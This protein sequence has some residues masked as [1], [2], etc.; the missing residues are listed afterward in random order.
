MSF[1]ADQLFDLVADVES[2]P[3]F[4]PWCSGARVISREARGGKTIMLADMTISFKIHQETF[5]SEV[6]LDREARTI[7]TRYVNGPFKRMVSEWR[8][9]PAGERATNVNFFIDFEFRN[10]AL[11]MLI[12]LLFEEAVRR[13]VAAFASRAEAIYGKSV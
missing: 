1:P 6:T 7:G 5:R 4:L 12:G 3:Q 2:Y 10:R 9:E 8:F 11:Q 13:I